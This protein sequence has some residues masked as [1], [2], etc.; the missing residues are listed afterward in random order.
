ML[1]LSLASPAKLLRDSAVLN[2]AFKKELKIIGLIRSEP[3][4]QNITSTMFYWLSNYNTC[5]KKNNKEYGVLN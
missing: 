3:E 5:S 1:L 4:I 2:R